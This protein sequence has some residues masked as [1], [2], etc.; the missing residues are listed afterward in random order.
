MLTGP[1]TTRRPPRPAASQAFL[2]LSL[3]GEIFHS[4]R[5]DEPLVLLD[6]GDCQASSSRYKS[7][8]RDSQR[9]IWLVVYKEVHLEAAP[10]RKTVPTWRFVQGTI[11]QGTQRPAPGQSLPRGERDRDLWALGPAATP[12]PWPD[13]PKKFAPSPDGHTQPTRTTQIH[14]R[15]AKH[16]AC[17]LASPG[18]LSPPRLHSKRERVYSGI[19]HL[20]SLRPLLGG[21]G[22]T[23]ADGGG[24]ED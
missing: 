1:E 22:K 3:P 16:T 12:G 21:R 14:Q 4:R 19:S 11:T 5:S 8:L 15:R 18:L 2:V 10:S 17:F 6:N 13:L 7:D 24:K 20:P 9:Q 23:A